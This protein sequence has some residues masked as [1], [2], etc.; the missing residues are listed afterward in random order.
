MNQQIET[1]IIGGGISGLATAWFLK[2]RGFEIE[3]LE[4]NVRP[5]GT[6]WSV[7]NQG[8]LVENGPNSTLQKP[9]REE[10]ALGRLLAGVG[11]ETEL[12]V[13]CEAAQKRYVLFRGRLVALP[14]SPLA[15]LITPIFSWLTKFG[16]MAEPFKGWVET[17]ES[18]A[19]F[20][21]RR[22]G[23]GF[24]DYAV[25]PFVSGV[26]AG[27]PERLSVRA[28]VARIYA[29]EQTYGSLLFGAVMMGK[30]AK[31]AGM[32]RGR[33][34]SF[35]T[36]MAQLP[37]TIV[38]RLGD[39]VRLG[40]RVE[41]LERV[42]QGW[43]VVWEQGERLAKRVIL[44]VPAYRAAQLIAPYSSEAAQILR[45]I[46][47]PP[48]ASLALGFDAKQVGHLLDGFGYLAPK[49]EEVK[50]LGV[51]FSSTL[52]IK[53]APNGKVLLTCFLG[54]ARQSDI[55]ERQDAELIDL[56]LVE[57]S[58][59]L[60][61]RGKPEMT[62]LTRHKQAIPQYELG[63][64]DRLEVFDRLVEENLPGLFFRANWRDGIS[65]ADCVLAAERLALNY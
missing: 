15:F 18:I 20:V 55:L 9:G 51:L 53:R 46:Y 47:Y 54:G 45:D 32:P 14:T 27:D 1:I 16:L 48:V 33:M 26:Y 25:D 31:G 56:V 39:T 34:I 65:V 40:V 12:Q 6:L 19:E 21:R 57:L 60:G 13:A 63:H 59:F 35:P 30:I 11:L 42:A 8:Y 10:D 24:L 49:K 62:Q 22:L 36:G 61:V 44:A 4:A 52:F 28:A 41:R 50:V 37:Q 64:L 58:K 23:Q 17:E 7:Q 2:Q 5:G 3:L 43:R 29:L 38:E